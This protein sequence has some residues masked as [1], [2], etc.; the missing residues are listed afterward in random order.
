MRVIHLVIAL[1]LTTTFLFG[2]KKSNKE[3]TQKVVGDL[4]FQ[5]VQFTYFESPTTVFNELDSLI[6]LNRGDKDLLIFLKEL[7]E[8]GM[9][10]TP[11]VNLKQDDRDDRY[12]ILFMDWESY[13]DL[14]YKHATWDCWT[15]KENGKK[16]GVTA[17]VKLIHLKSIP[18]P[19]YQTVKPPKFEIVSGKMN[20]Y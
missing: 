14:K 4:V 16:V 6:K 3:Q 19:V 5:T 2:Q 1:L 12:S 20:C 7:K 13:N 8:L 10:K 9:H 11:Y 18:V 17:E 15:L